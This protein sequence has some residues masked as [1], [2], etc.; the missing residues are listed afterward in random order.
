MLPILAGLLE[1][2]AANGLSM[3]AGAIQAK[4]KEVIEEKIGVKLPADASGLTPELV[5]RLKEK[6]IEH[7][8]FLVDAQIKQEVLKLESER[9]AYADTEGAR[10]MNQGIQ[11]STNASTLAKNAAYYLDFA[12]VG[13]AVLVTLLVL[14]VKLEGANQNMAFAAVGSLWTLAGTVVNFHRGTSKSSEK[15]GE[16]LHAALA[17]RSE[18]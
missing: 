4:G 8:E 13:G 17:Q 2:L 18:T 12:I 3:L 6:E 5:V 1:G 7:E 9:A 10:R 16:A 11:D 15:H 14:F